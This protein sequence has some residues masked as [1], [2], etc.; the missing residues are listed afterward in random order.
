MRE[1]GRGSNWSYCVLHF[2]GRT[3]RK[4]YPCGVLTALYQK[5]RVSTKGGEGRRDYRKG[6]LAGWQ[7]G[8]Q[9]V[10][11]EVWLMLAVQGKADP[12]SL[13]CNYYIHVR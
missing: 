1:G 2:R 4:V 3:H 6:R 11:E 5:D 12:G 7:A 13:F 10:F 9:C 8:R